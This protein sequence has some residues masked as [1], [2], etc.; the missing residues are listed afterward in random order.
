[1]NRKEVKLHALDNI[2]YIDFM[3]RLQDRYAKDRMQSNLLS[4]Q[5]AK[6]F[7]QDQ[8]A[9][10]LPEG[11]T[12]EG[13]FFFKLITAS[14]NMQIGESWLFINYSNQSAYIFELFLEANLRGKGLGKSSLYALEQFAKSEGANTL[15][16]NVFATN[17]IAKSLY[18]SFGF[19]DVSTDMIK[20]I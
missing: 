1:M 3:A 13:H 16:L 14:D 19:R 4:E 5:K 6:E 15:G 12:T 7:T 18:T 2:S 8:W 20:A 9:T 17:D 10:F 11:Q